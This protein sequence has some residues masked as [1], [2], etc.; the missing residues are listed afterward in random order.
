MPCP[1]RTFSWLEGSVANASFVCRGCGQEKDGNPRLCPGVQQYCGM[2][3]C[4]RKRKSAWSQQQSGDE[5]FRQ[6]QAEAQA[7]WRAK[8][9]SYDRDYRA[10]H[11]EAVVRNRLLQRVRDRR[12]RGA[13]RPPETQALRTGPDAAPLVPAGRYRLLSVDRPGA[14]A[15][16]VYVSACKDGRVP[17]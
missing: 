3:R 7:T 2:K 15:L 11:P 5:N 9:P 4:Q 10:T 17:P 16:D 8:R 1:A 12:R 13:K 14:P 6:N